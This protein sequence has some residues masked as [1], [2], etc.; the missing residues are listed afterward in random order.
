MNFE[1][2]FKDARS[3]GLIKTAL[4]Y[5]SYTLTDDNLKEAE[6]FEDVKKIMNEAI[7]QIEK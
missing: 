1:T 6:K 4:D 5:I 3:T 2:I 7:K